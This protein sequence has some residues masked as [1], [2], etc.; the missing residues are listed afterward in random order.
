MKDYDELVKENIK[1]NYKFLKKFDKEMKKEKVSKRTICK[2]ISNIGFYLNYYLNYYDI[3]TMEEGIHKTYGFFSDW[4]LDKYLSGSVNDLKTTITSVKK[5]YKVMSELGYVSKEDYK[6][7][8]QELKKNNPFFI[9]NAKIYYN[10][11]F[12]Y[13]NDNEVFDWF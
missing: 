5:F 7:L 4:Y 1:R 6:N 12:D 11:I 2:H 3:I 9:E 13:D 10:S 8:V